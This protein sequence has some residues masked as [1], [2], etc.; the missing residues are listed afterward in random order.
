MFIQPFIRGT[1]RSLFLDDLRRIQRLSGTRVLKGIK[2]FFLSDAA[3]E[4]E[5]E[6]VP[7]IQYPLVTKEQMKKIANDNYKF[8]YACASFAFHSNKSDP[9]ISSLSELSDPTQLTSLLPRRRPHGSPI[10]T[11]SIKAGD[12][13]MLVSPTILALADGVSG[14]EDGKGHFSSGVWSRSM[15]ETLSRLMTEYKISHAPYHLNKRDIYQ[16]LDDTYLHT[17]HLMDLQSLEGSSTLVFGMLSGKYLKMISIGDSKMYIIRDGE[18]IKSN[19][20]QMV[21]SLCPQQIGTHTLSKIPSEIAWVDS[22]KLELGDIIVMCSDGISD[23][24]YDWEIAHYVDTLLNLQR[25][26]LREATNKLLIKAKE[27]AF[28]DNIGTPYSEQVNAYN[29]KKKRNKFVTGGKLDDMSLC[30]AKVVSNEKT[31]NKVDI[32]RPS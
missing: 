9:I 14:W 10:D 11:L 7:Y 24:L 13:A 32:T 30:I 27:I 17:S 3:E 22:V 25:D 1:R 6:G 28:D 16:I 12:D 19:A 21:S 15:V 29:A 20:E 18:I 2:Q 8:E 4:D 26:N 31:S 23:N 5:D